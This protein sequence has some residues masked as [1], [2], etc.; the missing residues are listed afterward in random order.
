MN[1]TAASPRVP[2]Y[3]L[4]GRGTEMRRRLA[5]WARPITGAAIL[6]FLLARLG[7][8]PFLDALDSLT[9]GSVAM[10]V[11][12]G[13][14]TT[15]CAAWR[16]QLVSRALGLALP[17]RRAICAYYRSQFL[18]STLPGGVLGDLHRGIRHGRDVG[19]VGG[20]LR[21]VAWERCTGQAVQLTL[22][23]FVLALLPTPTRGVLPPLAAL[24]A[25]GVVGGALVLWARRRTHGAPGLSTLTT[26]LAGLVRPPRSAVR[27]VLA[28]VLVVAGH[29]AVFVIA[30]RASGVSLPFDRLLPVA[31]VVLTAAAVP[32][33]IAGWGPREGAAA[34]AFGV[35]G[36]GGAQG[37]T[38]ATVYGVLAL[39]ATLPGA[40]VL[41]RPHRGRPR[42]HGPEDAPDMVGAA[43]A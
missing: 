30:A 32:A 12:I 35:V 19:A 31:L 29:T 5:S 9:G 3:H 17:F 37:V 10:A 24:L 4:G 8:A 21:A 33:N 16:W 15:A 27:I 34:W 39:V 18:N 20:S 11:A 25:A 43:H 22:T 1:Q 38:T 41:L 40:V 42:R 2:L 7:A 13:A 6:A 23:V 36:L 26:D 14:A 28:S